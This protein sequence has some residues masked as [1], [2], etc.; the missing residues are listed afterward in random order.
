MLAGSCIASKRQALPPFD[1]VVRPVL[2]RLPL[3]HRKELAEWCLTKYEANDDQ[4]LSSVDALLD[5]TVQMAMAAEERSDAV[6][7]ANPEAENRYT[8]VIKTLASLKDSLSH[9]LDIKKSLLSTDSSS[10]QTVHA[11]CR[12]LASSLD[13][14]LTTKTNLA[15]D[16]I[17]DFVLRRSSE[18]A[19]EKCLAAAGFTLQQ[20]RSFSEKVHSCC[21]SVTDFHDEHAQ[22]L[23]RKWLFHGDENE[24]QEE[25]MKPQL[26]P[27]QR[28]L[29]QSSASSQDQDD[30]VMDISE[31]Q[32][33]ADDWKLRQQG[34]GTNKVI[35]SEEVSSI[36]ECSVREASEHLAQ[37]ASLRIAF[38][39]AFSKVRD[40]SE[41]KSKENIAN[42]SI[43]QSRLGQ[44]KLV[45]D[46]SAQKDIC[47]IHSKFLMAIVFANGQLL[48]D[49]S[50]ALHSIGKEI[51][52]VT[53]AM[54]HRALRVASILCPHD[55]LSE[56]SPNCLLP[57]CC[58]GVFVAKEV[59]EMGL[60]LPHSD[61]VQ[62]SSM[63]FTTYAR[64]L[65]MQHRK[66]E[67]KSQGR[68]LLLLC[69]MIVKEA[70]VDDA[71]LS[72]VLNEILRRRLP[73]TLL[74]AL[75]RVAGVAANWEISREHRIAEA[76][77]VCVQNIIGELSSFSP[78]F[79]DELCKPIMST[80]SMTHHILNDLCDA[81]EQEQYAK[82]LIDAIVS[83]G[84]RVETLCPLLL[85][86]MGTAY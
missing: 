78:D 41:E 13:D 80:L 40:I 67:L 73:R 46:K 84:G 52:T 59:E 63:N 4:K 27:L 30:F 54:R 58:F 48:S 85:D 16:E 38:V 33:S 42:R 75:D 55:V 51:R 9:V 34:R 22:N 57:R 31:I 32:D 12:D 7:E 29:R 76:I 43:G 28:R 50:Q 39:M 36:E 8:D 72:S 66:D 79:Y 15:N 20:F 3:L 45:A 35:A 71:N 69:E 19:A 74:L 68:F 62:L 21:R 61:L 44:Q 25:R 77:D 53:F 64:T 26:S 17:V 1:E 23:A 56:I 82:K 10:S 2:N 14:E 83:S 11:L 86:W 24:C 70:T 6:A 49:D 81:V 60:T 18:L 65:W 5:A 47:E 37:R